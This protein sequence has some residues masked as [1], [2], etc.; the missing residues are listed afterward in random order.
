MAT[1]VLITIDTE[2]AWR[3]FARG[4]PWRELLA[5]SYDPAGVGVPY[6]LGQL[7]RFGL[8][9][10][11]FVDPM[12]ALVY[13]IEPVRMMV[14]PIL[15]AG[16]E[17]QLHL[18]SFWSDLA[19]GERDRARFELTLFDADQQYA[20][21]ATARDLLVE[22]GA[23]PP[24]AFRSGS[25]AADAGTLAA[26]RRLGL[27]HDSSH[28]GAEHPSPS[29]LPLAPELIDPAE[30]DGVTEIPVS[31]IRRRDGGLRPFQICALSAQEMR[32]ALRHADARDH[33]VVTIVGHSF[34]LAS[35]DGR[36][37]NRLVRGRFDRL[38]AFLA[39][40]AT[41][42]PTVAFADLPALAVAAPSRPLPARPLRTARRIGEQAWGNLRY[43]RPL[44]ATAAA[45]AAGPPL[46]A[47]GYWLAHAGL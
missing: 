25:Y 7:R 39:D 10:C 19:R 28:N 13:G 9:A 32:A 33:P 20:L 30:C 36:R 3:H 41:T 17:V 4:A 35:R 40:H 14:E 26:L 37:V 43:E 18:H 11:F 45:A 15:A 31:Q 42:M 1:R 23:P 27:R 46:A 2:L 38:C 12:P 5:L 24:T 6:Q 44:M 16:Q 34:E 21:I 8:K 47:L 22:A 29:A